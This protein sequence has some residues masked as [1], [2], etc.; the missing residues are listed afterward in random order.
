M[1][2]EKNNRK[3]RDGREIMRRLDSDELMVSLYMVCNENIMIFFSNVKLCT[4]HFHNPIY[5]LTILNIFNF[6]FHLSPLH[7]KC[8]ESCL[9]QVSA[10]GQSDTTK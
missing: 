1:N 6:Y 9:C 3:E 5:K 7:L 10:I 2:M 8:G 4:V